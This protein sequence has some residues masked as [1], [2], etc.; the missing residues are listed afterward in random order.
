M[1]R[2]VM[3]HKR[4]YTKFYSVK[5]DDMSKL[6]DFILSPCNRGRIYKVVDISRKDTRILNSKLHALMIKRDA[7]LSYICGYGGIG[8]RIDVDSIIL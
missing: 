8:R 4:R 3:A 5:F 6:A 7:I 1:A 2:V